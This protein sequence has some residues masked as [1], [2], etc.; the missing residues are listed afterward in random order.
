MKLGHLV[1][2]TTSQCSVYTTRNWNTLVIFDLRDRAVSLIVQSECQ[3]LQEYW[4]Y[5]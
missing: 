3:I 2:T 4:S 5:V 1:V